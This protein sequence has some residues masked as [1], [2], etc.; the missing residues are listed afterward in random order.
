MAT[1]PLGYNCVP[2]MKLFLDPHNIPIIANRPALG[3]YPCDCWPAKIENLIKKVSP[4]LPNVTTSSCESV[5]IETAIKSMMITFRNAQ[6]GGE[7][8][9]MEELKSC[10]RNEPPGSSKL[11]ILSFKNASHGCTLGALSA[12][13]SDPYNK[14][15]I[16]SFDWPMA[17][18]PCY[19]YPLEEFACYNECQDSKSVSMV[20]ELI[21]QWNKKNKPVVGIIVEPIQNECTES[22]SP[23]FF[24]KLQELAKKCGIYLLL[25]ETKTGCGATGKFWCHEN[26]CLSFPPDA[27][28]FGGKSQLAGFFHSE[29]LCQRDANR[30]LDTWNGD[31]SKMLVFETVLD[32]IE[33]FNLLDNV[34]KTG[35]FMKKRLFELEVEHYDLIHSTRGMGTMLAFNAQCPSLRDDISERLRKKE[36]T[37]RLSS[38]KGGGQELVPGEPDGPCVRTELPGPKTKAL[39][40]DLEKLQFLGSIQYFADYDKSIG[41][42]IVDADDNVF[43]DTYTQIA[44]VPLGY[45]HPEILKA[46]TDEHNLRCLVN[47]PALGVFPGVDWPKRMENIIKQ[48]SPSLPNITT[49]MCGSCSNENAFKNTFIAYKRKMRG[50]DADFTDEEKKTA[51]VNQP[52]GSAKLSILSF[53]GAF[54]GRTLGALSTTHSKAIHKLDFPAFD[55]PIAHFPEYKYPLKENVRENQKED[56]K[57]LAEVEDLMETYKKK[58]CPVAGVIV[59]PIQSEGGDN[60]ASPEF[61]QCLQKICKK[62][63]AAL[64]IDEVQTGCGSTGKM[65]CHEHFNLETPP[66]IVTFS[67]K[68]QMA[69]YFHSKEMSPKKPYR[70]FNTWMGDPGKTILLERIVAFIKSRNLL[71]QVQR[72]GECLISGLMEMEKDFPC[73]LSAARGRGTLTAITCTTAELRDDILKRM[74]KKGIQG[75]GCGQKSIRLRPALVFQERHVEIFL[76]IFRQVMQEIQ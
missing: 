10:L 44:T 6:R 33:K 1:I 31:P 37:I 2:L 62:H 18:Y 21:H 28:A 67:K 45:N 48:I 43:L 47:R 3:L 51:M 29:N 30:K 55:W 69:G 41:N 57:C 27:V 50:E 66:D 60:H 49:M 19:K 68:M 59:E 74:K 9:S 73:H 58:N 35:D 15:D 39:F 34:K 13:H 25:D 56:E 64:I 38:Q 32:L 8:I 20:E 40:K 46:F 14:L 11:S 5:A 76:D 52:P 53:F 61:F 24:K 12:S 65:W 42:Y 4:N 72:S 23:Q 71:E 7:K 70:V 63:C 22:P 17:T 54:H 26:F 75:G 36:N 16:P